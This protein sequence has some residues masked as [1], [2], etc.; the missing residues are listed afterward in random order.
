M[1]TIRQNEQ[2][3]TDVGTRRMHMKLAV[4]KRE[5]VWKRESNATF[6]SANVEKKTSFLLDL[7]EEQ[8][9]KFSSGCAMRVNISQVLLHSKNK[10]FHNSSRSKGSQ[11]PLKSRHNRADHFTRRAPESLVCESWHFSPSY[12]FVPGR[13]ADLWCCIDAA[14][15]AYL[16]STYA[17]LQ[18][19]RSY[20][21]L[22]QGTVALTIHFKRTVL[23]TA[24]DYTALCRGCH[25]EKEMCNSHVFPLEIPTH[26]SFTLQEQWILM[27]RVSSS[28]VARLTYTR[29]A[30][31][32]NLN[33][34]LRLFP[35]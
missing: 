20:I 26:N 22:P 29:S 32:A 24:P 13:R 10:Q 12:P 15:Y 18:P 1:G 17:F 2:C 5:S 21:T 19:L 27:R 11:V 3:K 8:N 4:R 6:S 7:S 28:Q 14:L 30:L 16:V 35:H 9:L 23:G 34:F 31:F 33:P 25:K